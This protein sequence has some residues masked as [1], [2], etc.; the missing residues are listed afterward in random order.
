MNDILAPAVQNTSAARATLFKFS[1]LLRKTNHGPK[2]LSYVAPSI[3]GTW[4]KWP[5]FLKTT[6]N[7]NTKTKLKIIFF[8]E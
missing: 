5:D 4:N 2:G 1:Q 8:V 7:V 6:E 3:C